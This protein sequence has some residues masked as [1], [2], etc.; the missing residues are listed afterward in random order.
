MP[1]LII[2]KG[3]SVERIATTLSLTTEG[4]F[5][6]PLGVASTFVFIFILFGAFLDKTGAGSFF[7]NLS[8]SITGRFSGQVF[9]GSVRLSLTSRE[10]NHARQI[11]WGAPSLPF[12]GC[13]R[14]CRND[15][16][17]TSHGNVSVAPVSIRKKE[18]PSGCRIREDGRI[19]DVEGWS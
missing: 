2:H 18:K 13:L 12:S 15:L 11:S 10:G 19:A 8:Y 1:E 5:G 17:S 7:I 6:L 16:G 3:Y 4:I 14:Q 9:A